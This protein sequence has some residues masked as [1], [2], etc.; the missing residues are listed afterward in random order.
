MVVERA[1]T[2][3]FPAWAMAPIYKEE[4]SKIVDDDSTI[5]FNKCNAKESPTQLRIALMNFTFRKL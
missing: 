4:S 5:H 2:G 3:R 1:P